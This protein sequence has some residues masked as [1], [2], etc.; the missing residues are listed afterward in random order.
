MKIKIDYYFC[1]G[2]YGE[3]SSSNI[4]ATKDTELSV[5]LLAIL[6]KHSKKHK[7]IWKIELVDNENID[8]KQF[9]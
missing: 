4:N 7:N 5:L 9:K 2:I 3:H 6:K 1:S 8:I